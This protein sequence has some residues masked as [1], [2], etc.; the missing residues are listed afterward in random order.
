MIA[1]PNGAG[2]TTFAKTFLPELGCKIFVNADLIAGGIAPLA[3]EEAAIKAGKLL[4][5]EI[6]STA[7]KGVNFGFE[8]TL[9]GRSH[10]HLFQELAQ[11]GYAIH[12]FF[13]WLPSVEISLKR[14]GERVARGGHHIPEPVA[15]RRF[16]RGIENLFLRYNEILSSWIIFDNSGNEPKT[17][18]YRNEEKTVKV[19]EDEPFL[20]LKKMAGAQ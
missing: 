2:K 18:A 6:R 5:N 19:L 11:Q 10:I 3:P 7:K 4:L 15:R 9:S 14:I 8:T 20:K 12:L 1:G 16:Y 13:L 17:I